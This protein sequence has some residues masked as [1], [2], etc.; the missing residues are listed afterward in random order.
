MTEVSLLMERRASSTRDKTTG[1]HLLSD[2]WRELLRHWAAWRVMEN[3]LKPSR[4][5][6]NAVG[7]T[8]TPLRGKLSH[9]CK[10]VVLI[11]EETAKPP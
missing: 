7:A 9:C 11:G 1:V 6:T 4:R 5:G 10:F 2:S 8:R 3:E